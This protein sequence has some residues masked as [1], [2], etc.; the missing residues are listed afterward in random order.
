M[1]YSELI[2][3]TGKGTQPILSNTALINFTKSKLQNVAF[4]KCN[5]NYYILYYNP[6]DWTVKLY[7]SCSDL[8]PTLP[9]PYA[10]AKCGP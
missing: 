6:K 7:Q 3:F 10:S 4:L 8:K 2:F 9:R 1:L 5:D